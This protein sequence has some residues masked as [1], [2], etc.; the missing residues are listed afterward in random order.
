MKV[1]VMIEETWTQEFEVE[2]DETGLDKYDILDAAEE[3]AIEMYREGKI[4]L[5]YSGEA[6]CYH[7]EIGVV[8]PE[9]GDIIDFNEFYV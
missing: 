1:K 5:D 7:R 8:E 2:I 4:E 3:K 6:E 9:T